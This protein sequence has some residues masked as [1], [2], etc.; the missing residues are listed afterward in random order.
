MEKKATHSNSKT[1]PP[2]REGGISLPNV[3]MY[4]LACLLRIGLD[5]ISKAS[6][7]SNYPM[8]SVMAHPYSLVALLHCKWKTI[9]LDLQHNLLLRD[10][11]IAWRE[12]RKRMDNKVFSLWQ[13]KGLTEFS[14]LCDLESGTPHAFTVIAERFS[15]PKTH[16]FLLLAMH[17]LHLYHVRGRQ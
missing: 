10:T 11:V 7:Y 17:Q 8:V 16:V 9:H 13:Q 15:L 12:T 3:R 6:R 5:W 2:R 4:N 1:L 14:S